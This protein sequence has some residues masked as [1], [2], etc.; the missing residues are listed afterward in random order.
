MGNFFDDYAIVYCSI[1]IV[2]GFL[3]LFMAIKM[4]RDVGSMD[5]VKTFRKMVISETVVII[6][7][8]LW[9]ISMFYHNCFNHTLNVFVN[10]IDLIG[11]VTTLYYMMRFVQVKLAPQNHLL[12]IQHSFLSKALIV[13]LVIDIMVNVLSLKTHWVFYVD[14]QGIYHRGPYYLV[15]VLCCY[16]YPLMTFA[17]LLYFSSRDLMQRSKRKQLLIFLLFP[18]L[19]ALFQV[20]VGVAPFSVMTSMLGMFYLFSSMQSAHIN[21]DALTGL[22][23]RNRSREYL[24]QRIKN[25]NN[26]PFYL[27]LADINKFKKINDTYGHLKGDQALVCIAETFKEFGGMYHSFFASRYGGDEFLLTIDASD[28][29]IEDLKKEL[30]R[31][32]NQNI[33]KQKIQFSIALSYGYSY[34]DRGTDLHTILEEAD[35]KLYQEKTFL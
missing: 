12:K 9:M 35:Q 26:S 8:L 30:T 1:V 15:Q 22:N 3:M 31:L 13:P 7:E 34:C 20:F 27:I 29:K 10:C 24:E 11:A 5:E 23:N 18:L 16:F 33:K 14:G 2:C 28:I 21:T 19:G 32:L 6:M 25:A 4:D 17:L